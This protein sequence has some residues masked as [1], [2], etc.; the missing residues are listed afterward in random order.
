MNRKPD[1]IAILRPENKILREIDR[2]AYEARKA[3]T[4]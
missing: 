3:E 2:L 1:H 4:E